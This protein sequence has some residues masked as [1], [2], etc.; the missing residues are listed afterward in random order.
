MDPAALYKDVGRRVVVRRTELGVT[1]ADLASRVSL[2]RA[3]IANIERGHQKLSLHQ[4]Y[5]LAE[6][7]GL[8]TV[9]LLPDAPT[10]SSDVAVPISKGGGELSDVA[11]RQVEQ[12][13]N[14]LDT[15]P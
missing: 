13:F 2:S 5:L 15:A 8:R 6:A 12:L 7:L 4:V 1:Q 3:S 11:L 9:D 10:A 14:D